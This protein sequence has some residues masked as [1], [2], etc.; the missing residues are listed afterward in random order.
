MKLNRLA[1]SIVLFSSFFFGFYEAHRITSAAEKKQEENENINFRWAFCVLKKREPDQEL[2]NIR[3]DTTL[4]TGDRIKMS[5][6]P[7]KQCFLYVIYHGS[8][9]EL[10]LLFPYDLRRSKSYYR[11]GEKY[12]I[13][14][15]QAWFELDDHVGRE[16]FFLLASVYR[17]TKLEGLIEDYGSAEPSKKRQL[18]TSV[19]DEIRKLKREHSK[20]KTAA[21]RPVAVVGRIR[22]G[23]EADTELTTEISKYA[24]E[25]A[26]YTFYSRTYTIEHK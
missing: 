16:T 13:P 14:K 20:F 1:V 4:K 7:R 22:G 6:E 12:Y 3:G 23:R 2:V 10:R 19:L 26:A 25:V 24:I 21:E 17:L 5:L 9:G 15:G 18:T 11:T 8:R